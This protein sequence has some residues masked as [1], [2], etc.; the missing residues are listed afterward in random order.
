MRS[1]T[2]LEKKPTWKTTRKQ[3]IQITNYFNAGITGLHQEIQLVFFTT[4]KLVF[5]SDRSF[6]PG[7]QKSGSLELTVLLDCTVSWLFCPLQ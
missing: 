7:A 1:F 3:Q 2:V 6:K 4:K 5:C